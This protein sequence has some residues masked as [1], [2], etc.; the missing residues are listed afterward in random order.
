[1]EAKAII[2]WSP[3]RA[4]TLAACAQRYALQYV[5]GAKARITPQDKPARWLGKQGRWRAPMDCTVMISRE[6]LRLR[7]QDANEG[8]V[9]SEAVVRGEF[10]RRLKKTLDTQFD[11][12]ERLARRMGWNRTPQRR[13]TKVRFEKLVEEGMKR[14]LSAEKHPL[15]A[16]LLKSPKDIEWMVPNQFHTFEANGAR[17]YSAPDL[18]IREGRKWRLVRIS[19][20][21]MKVKPA[22]V[23]A[24]EMDT[25]FLWAERA[26]GLP[27]GAHRFKLSRFGWERGKW[28]VWTQKGSKRSRENASELV[29]ND[30]QAMRHAKRQMGPAMDI[31]RLPFAESEWRCRECPYRW[32]CQGFNNPKGS[33]LNQEIRERRLADSWKNAVKKVQ[34]ALQEE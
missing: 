18:I 9:W 15:L 7:L 13:V 5:V 12:Q 30:I 21:V 3:T 4:A 19:G 34:N 32:N 16:R 23:K 29:R 10:S 20:D 2:P 27:N 6:V 31:D 28:K 25:M 24:I 22:P 14:L 1:M 11:D 17:L 33:R 26:E 8:T